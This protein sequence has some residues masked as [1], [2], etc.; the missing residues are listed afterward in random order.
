MQPSDGQ[1]SD[2]WSFHVE[3]G[4][5]DAPPAPDTTP[6][7]THHSEPITWT[8]SEFISQHKSAGW[9]LLFFMFI[10]AVCVIVYVISKEI[11]PVVSIAVMGVLFSI[12]ASHKPRQ[13]QYLI[14]DHGLQIGNKAYSF[15]DFKSFSLQK[16]G[17]IGYVSLLPL[18]RLHPEIS[19]Y[20]APEDEQR[21]FE[22]L[23]QHIPNEQRSES[24]VDKLTKKIRF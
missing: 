16:D 1:N 9:Y 3:S 5:A 20:F 24:A 22:A 6:E 8:G 2:S 21:I 23:A 19:I 15:N 11:L 4:S 14:D 12:I 17:A 7:E 18:K 10:A 13:L